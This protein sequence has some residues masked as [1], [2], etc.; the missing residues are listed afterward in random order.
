MFTRQ[1]F[2]VAQASRVAQTF[3]DALPVLGL[4]LALG[5]CSASE[6]GYRPSAAPA[7]GFYVGGSA[8]VSQPSDQRVHS[9]DP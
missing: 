4:L 2:Y 5:A 8:G 3:R 1:T 7:S 9:A 6:R